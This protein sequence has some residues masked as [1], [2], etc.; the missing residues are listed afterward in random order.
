MIIKIARPQPTRAD[1]IMA[2]TGSTERDRGRAQAT[3][4]HP[5]TMIEENATIPR[6]CTLR[7]VPIAR[8]AMI[9]PTASELAIAPISQTPAP[10]TSR[11][12]LGRDT[13][14]GPAKPTLTSGEASTGT[15]SHV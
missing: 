7:A 9:E 13:H 1:A 4:A 5:P 10:Y 2:I 12:N 15:H 3:S 6:R 11:T 14:I 8:A